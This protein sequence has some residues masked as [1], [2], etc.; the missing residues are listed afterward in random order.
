MQFVRIS[1]LIFALGFFFACSLGTQ[2]YGKLSLSIEVPD[3]LKTETKSNNTRFIH[4]NGNILNFELYTQRRVI[5]TQTITL[6]PQPNNPNPQTVSIS[7]D[8]VPYN[9]SLFAKITVYGKKTGENNESILGQNTIDI[10]QLR[11][12]TQKLTLGVKPVSG[13]NVA[14]EDLGQGQGQGQDQVINLFEYFETSADTFNIEM[15]PKK[16]LYTFSVERYADIYLYDSDGKNYPNSFLIDTVEMPGRVFYHPEDKASTYY[17][18]LSEE[19]YYLSGYK[20][21]QDI[22]ITRY[23]DSMGGDEIVGSEGDVYFDQ[24]SSDN[25]S[26]EI[27]FTIYNPY[28]FTLNLKYKIENADEV[29]NPA[30]SPAD[31]KDKFKFTDFPKVLLPGK[32]EKFT[33]NFHPDNSGDT[34]R[35]KST[36]SAPGAGVSDF[37]LLFTGTGSGT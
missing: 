7:I 6:N 1:L 9:V 11:Y 24:L 21:D 37:V 18:Y 22:L 28:P 5:H 29:S 33:V 26:K 27:T 4:P 34:Y 19:T 25:P 3:Y 32:S 36:I 14:Y 30:P 15:F 31:S 13:A 17:A 12:P 8:K 35:V 16:G 20:L 2:R 23:E 10:G